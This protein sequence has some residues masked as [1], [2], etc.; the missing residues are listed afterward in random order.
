M[1]IPIVDLNCNGFY[2][3]SSFGEILSEELAKC[4]GVLSDD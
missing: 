3:R 1:I 4:S 2:G